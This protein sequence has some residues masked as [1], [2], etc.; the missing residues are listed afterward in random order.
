MLTELFNDCMKEKCEVP[1]EWKHTWITP[2]YKNGNKKNHNN[3]L[4][5]NVTSSIGGYMDEY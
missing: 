4:C 3:Y 1:M 2:I 5:I